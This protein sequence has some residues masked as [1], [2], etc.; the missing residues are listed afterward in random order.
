MVGCQ[1]SR[2]TDILPDGIRMQQDPLSGAHIHPITLIRHE[3]DVR[4]VYQ[5]RSRNQCALARGQGQKRLSTNKGIERHIWRLT[6]ATVGSGHLIRHR[7]F[8]F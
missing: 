6:A 3:R 7:T 4:Y 2:G 5:G 1:R 8:A